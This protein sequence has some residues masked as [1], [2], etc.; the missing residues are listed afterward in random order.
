MSDLPNSR[1]STRSFHIFALM[2]NLSTV[3]HANTFASVPCLIATIWVLSVKTLN[4][5][6]STISPS[7]SPDPPPPL[8]ASVSPLR[9]KFSLTK[10]VSLSGFPVT[11]LVPCFSNHWLMTSTSNIVPSAVQTGCW[12]GCRLAAQKLK[13]SLLKDPVGAF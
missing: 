9:A 6:G 8:C 4:V 10:S 2:F 13:G 11:G 7:P 12:K 3:S 5:T 1:S